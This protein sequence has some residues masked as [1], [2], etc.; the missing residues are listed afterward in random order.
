[1]PPAPSYHARSC[2]SFEGYLI[3]VPLFGWKGLNAPCYLRG[4]HVRKD[5]RLVMTFDGALAEAFVTSRVLAS[6]ILY[7]KPWRFRLTYGRP[8]Y[9]IMDLRQ[10]QLEGPGA[11][12]RVTRCACCL[13]VGMDR[14]GPYDEAAN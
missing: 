14:D 8:D 6:P 11:S 4:F 3:Y 12:W 5:S 10:P 7:A 1:M 13:C 9:S 2:A